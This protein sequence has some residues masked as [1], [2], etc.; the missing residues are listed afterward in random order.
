M[1]AGPPPC[2][3][4]YGSVSGF[5]MLCAESATRCEFFYDPST[6]NN[7]NTACNASRCIT[8]FSESSGDDC[9][10]ST[11]RPC[12]TVSNNQ[13]CVCERTE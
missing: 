2:D 8:A 1:D 6:D 3:D 4:L 9:G 7:C 11:E 10:R 13:I 5:I 12:D